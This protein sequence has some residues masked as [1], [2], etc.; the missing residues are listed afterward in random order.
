MSMWRDIKRGFGLGLG[1]GFGGSIGL[2]LGNMVSRW[3]GRLFWLIGLALIVLFGKPAL[4]GVGSSV[5]AYNDYAR[6]HPIHK[7]QEQQ[8]KE[9]KH[10]NK[11]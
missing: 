10:V 7:Q 6:S 9:R 8:K 5:K 2:N 3:V 1:A 4:D 11:Y